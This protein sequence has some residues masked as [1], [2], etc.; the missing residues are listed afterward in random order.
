MRFKTIRPLFILFSLCLYA[1]LL[2]A[3]ENLDWNFKK[4]R[5]HEPNASFFTPATGMRWGIAARKDD[6]QISFRLETTPHMD[7]GGWIGDIRAPEKFYVKVY[8]TDSAGKRQYFKLRNSRAVGPD[9]KFGSWK[10]GP[11]TIAQQIMVFDFSWDEILKIKKSKAIILNYSPYDN[12][13]DNKDVTIP[14]ATFG[15]QIDELEASIKDS[16]NKSRFVMTKQEI[17]NTPLIDLPAVIRT[18]WKDDLQQASSEI[19]LPMDELMKLSMK[20]IQQLQ[21]DRTKA[22]REAKLAKRR[23]AHQAVYDQEPQWLDIN[24]CPKPDVSFC[25]NV[26]KFAYEDNDMFT[27]LTHEYGKILGVVW[28]SKKL[29]RQS[30]WGH[31]RLEYQSENLPGIYCKILLHCQRW[32]WPN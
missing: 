15:V 10:K 19:S 29:Y 16:D 6:I 32:P 22:I 8:L 27:D 12:P 26:G 3:A 4:E 30:I 1:P 2:S 17:D 31:C 14:L 28:R 9:S 21:K 5:M 11:S 25:N 20:E 7:K 18:Y 13:G 23:K 24:L